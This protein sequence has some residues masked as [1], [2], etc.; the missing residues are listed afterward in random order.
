MVF[1]NFINMKGG[2]LLNKEWQSNPEGGLFYFI[3][4]CRK[5]KIIFDTSISCV[6]YKFYDLPEGIVSPYVS[7]RSTN[8]EQPVT[9][10]LFKIGLISKNSGGSEYIPCMRSKGMDTYDGEIQALTNSTVTDEINAQ[11]EIYLKS[12]TLDQITPFEALCP[13][14][15]CYSLD[16]SFDSKKFIF[17]MIL[18]KLKQRPGD[19]GKS[20]KYV[21]SDKQVTN[22]LYDVKRKVSIIVMEFMDDYEN[23]SEFNY[24]SR[25]DYFKLMHSYEL[26]RLGYYGY[27]HL[28]SHWGN[29]MINPNYPYFTNDKNSPWRGKALIIDF[30]RIKCIKGKNIG[31][32]INIQYTGRNQ[33]ITPHYRTNLNNLRLAMASSFIASLDEEKKIRLL[34]L[35]ANNQIMLNLKIFPT[36]KSTKMIEDERIE[37]ERIKE[38]LENAKRRAREEEQRREAERIEAERRAREEDER[39]AREEEQRREAKRI[40]DERIENERIE[41]ECKAEFKSREEALE[42]ASKKNNTEKI[43]RDAM[44]WKQNQQTEEERKAREAEELSKCKAKKE[45][46]RRDREESE[47]MSFYSVKQENLGES[48]YISLTQNVPSASPI[49]GCFGFWMWARIFNFNAPNK[50]GGSGKFIM[51]GGNVDQNCPN[52]S[53]DINNIPKCFRNQ[54]EFRDMSFKLHP[55]TNSNCSEE[56]KIRA[57]EKFKILNSNKEQQNTNYGEINETTYEICMGSDDS[58]LSI[59]KE[60]EEIEILNKKQEKMDSLYLEAMKGKEISK[61]V[62]EKII[63]IFNLCNEKGEKNINEINN[64]FEI[65]IEELYKIIEFKNKI[66]NSD[67][68]SISDDN[69]NVSKSKLIIENLKKNV[70]Q[71]I[72]EYREDI[73]LL[74]KDNGIHTTSEDESLLI[75]CILD[76]TFRKY[77]INIETL[78][79]SINSI[80]G[81]INIKNGNKINLLD[82][83]FGI[84]QNFRIT[85]NGGLSN[86]LITINNNTQIMTFNNKV[87]VYGLKYELATTPLISLIKKYKIGTMKI[88][89]LNITSQQ[90]NNN[91]ITMVKEPFVLENIP[92]TGGKINK[93]I[94]KNKTKRVKKNKTK[95]IIKNKK[96]QRKY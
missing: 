64:I 10:I 90:F 14:I 56:D 9:S 75:T 63:F 46:E 47:K 86:E 96:T 7:I 55:D 93:Q 25:I 60:S 3:N 49:H 13:A 36:L 61:V 68:Q 16:I 32:Q 67:S 76:V 84:P 69:T 80:D 38:D 4:N 5:A 59:Q 28:D 18:S 31:Q 94:I 77:V 87:P 95:K 89:N 23:M 45:E 57:I 51:K 91:I 29:V 12:S 44:K 74:L 50:R 30:G 92:V 26:Y 78:N 1:K 62:T 71:K 58:N 73:S 27:L 21:I 33:V 19:I 22:N 85:Q 6:C 39:I 70:T 53:I 65:I 8:L 83:W 43:Y 20:G 88:S 72:K 66:Y 48:A 24:D 40:E 34:E 82:I 35:I 54:K 81:L 79:N 41:A 11:H 17:D 42:E 52:L 2:V 15:I 37:S